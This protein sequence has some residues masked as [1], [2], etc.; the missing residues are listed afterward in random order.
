M[1]LTRASSCTSR[2]LSE[3][4]GRSVELTLVL[5]DG[6]PVKSWKGVVGRKVKKAPARRCDEVG[7]PWR[8][9]KGDRI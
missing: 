2:L 3:S 4:S 5:G 6:E 8:R 9:I 7:G 1:R